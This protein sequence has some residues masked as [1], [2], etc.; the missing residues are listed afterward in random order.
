MVETAPVT[1]LEG[2][3]PVTAL[4]GTAP[5]TALEGTGG[6]YPSRTV[7]VESGVVVH[8]VQYPVSYMDSSGL[9]I[10]VVES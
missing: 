10:L 4:E 1:I 7:G 6:D 8:A 3:A 2:T 5:V 9:R